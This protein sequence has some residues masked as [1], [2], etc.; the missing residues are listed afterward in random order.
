[1][2]DL[3]L[4]LYLKSYDI[5]NEIYE[6][7]DIQGCEDGL[8]IKYNENESLVKFNNDDIRKVAGVN[9]QGEA[10]L[11]FYQDNDE[12]I[13]KYF[14][15]TQLERIGNELGLSK[16]YLN[17][18][19]YYEDTIFTHKDLYE[20]WFSEEAVAGGKAYYIFDED[21]FSWWQDLA[22]SEKA[23]QLYQETLT[24]EEDIRKFHSLISGGYDVI[25][26]VGKSLPTYKKVVEEA[27]EERKSLVKELNTIQENLNKNDDKK[28]SKKD[29]EL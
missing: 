1:M 15:D 2:E 26:D 8:Y 17:D 22:F 23:V 3:Y 6:H 4:N 27:S 9:L 13:D 10:L 19:A 25:I 18:I 29:I 16:Y 14:I 20:D 21:N 5:V 11:D 24:D 12:E 28:E 7:G